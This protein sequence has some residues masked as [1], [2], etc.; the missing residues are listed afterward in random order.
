MGQKSRN[1]F[2]SKFAFVCVREREI[3]RER[4][5]VR[6]RE[7]ER[8]HYSKILGEP[9]TFYNNISSKFLFQ[10]LMAERKNER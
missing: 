6:E 7:R 8:L 9:A 5:C 10:S 4:E 3:D 1:L 2:W